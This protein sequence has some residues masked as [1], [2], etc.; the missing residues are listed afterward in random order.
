MA[1]IFGIM[2]GEGVQPT[3]MGPAGGEVREASAFADTLHETGATMITPIAQDTER[4]IAPH[5]EGFDVQDAAR[6]EVG[7]DSW[8]PQNP[9]RYVIEAP[10]GE[11]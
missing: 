9:P 1:G 5:A 2:G 7:R 4:G 10:R 6:S 3:G 8:D 11:V